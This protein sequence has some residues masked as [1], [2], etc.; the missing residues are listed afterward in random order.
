[1]QEH[2]TA[3]PDAGLHPAGR[4]WAGNLTYRAARLHRPTSVAEVQELVAR[5]P[6]V[7]ALGSRHCFNDIA[8]TPADLVSLDALE[9]A[10]ASAVA[11]SRRSRAGSPA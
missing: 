5:S 1:M 9:G 10:A 6:R 8:D 4:N 7:K 2:V 11:P 3:G